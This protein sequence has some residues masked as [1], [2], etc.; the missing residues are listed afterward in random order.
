[1]A[2]HNTKARVTGTYEPISIAG[3]TARAFTPHPL[4]PAHPPLN[5]DRRLL[6][7]RHESE[8]KLARLDLAGELVPSIDWFIYSF[9]RKEVVVSS[10]IEGTQATLQDLLTLEADRQRQE[11]DVDPDLQEICSAL[12]A[13]TYARGCL[14]D[15]NAPPLCMRS[16][17]QIHERLMQGVR[18]ADKAPGYIRRC[19]NWIGGDHPSRAHFVP[20]PPHRLADAL[21]ALENYIHT[22]DSLAPLIRIGLIHAQFETIHPY[23]D[24]NGRMGRLLI[25]L[26]LEQTG[27]LSEPLLPLSLFFKHHRQDY[28]QRL[29]AVRT[30]GDWEGWIEFFLR[31]VAHTAQGA[32]A[33]AQELFA[34]VG[35]DRNEFLSSASASV[36]AL[37]LFEQLPKHPI[38]TVRYAMELLTTTKPTAIKAIGTL[39]DFGILA[40]TS[41]R[42]RDR[43]FGYTRY[44]AKLC[45][46]TELD[47]PQAST[48][49][50]ASGKG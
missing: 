4:P 31:G 9:V 23:L 22:Q 42:K 25:L 26:L 20:P 5:P 47:T 21:A 50:P 44:L 14:R 36:T 1:M 37:R 34:L 12:N 41:G 7:L 6:H 15:A 27:L 38:V 24:G 17:N 48:H 2:A 45:A 28:Y 40:E 3:G 19:Q 49:Q 13:L 46:G 18:G 16:C 33:S 29:N 43:T 11:K 30:H 35:A 10:Q 32:I 8:R 39:V